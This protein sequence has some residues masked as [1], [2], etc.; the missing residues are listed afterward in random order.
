MFY[1][2]ES[3]NLIKKKKYSK[4]TAANTVY[5][6]WIVLSLFNFV[7]S[8]EG[9]YTRGLISGGAYTRGL[10][11]GGVYPGGLYPGTYI[12]GLITERGF[13]FPD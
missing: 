11:S 4:Q 5:P 12:R 2:L 10:I 13:L 9:V 8:F 6:A 7:R 3:H 1:A